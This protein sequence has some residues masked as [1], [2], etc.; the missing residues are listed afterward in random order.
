MI[1]DLTAQP[2][3]LM[4]EADVLVIGAG[5]AGLL[6]ASELRKSRVSVIVLESGAREQNDEVHP[7]NRVVQLADEYHGATYGRSRCLG[8]TSTR[9]GGALIP[10]LPFDL[11]ARTHAGLATWPIRLNEV[12]PFLRPIEELFAV[13][14]GSYDEAFVEEYGA[15]DIIP[16]GD[17]DFIPRFAKWPRFSRRNVAT[18]LR[19]QIE[20]DPDLSIWLNATATGFE[21]DEGTRRVR[22]VT[23]YH[24]GGRRIVVTADRIVICAGAIESTRLL[25]LLDA[26][27]GNRVFE[28]NETLG[29]YLS[30]HI[31]VRTA[32]I[33]K[34]QAVRLNRLAGF[35]FVGGTMRSLRFEL[36]PSAQNKERI[37]C[38]FGHISFEAIGET[39]FD[40]L[41]SLLREYQKS[42]RLR[43]DLAL[44]TL[45]DFPYLAR[46]LAWRCFHRQLHWPSPARYDLHTV[47]EQL[48]RASNSI[49]LSHE[50]DPFGNPL[51][52][53]DWKIHSRD[54]EAVWAYARRFDLYWKR[55][56]LSKIGELAWVDRTDGHDG[57]EILAANDIYH[58]CGTT[59]MGADRCSAV[60]DAN[61]RVWAL[62]NL[63]VA[64]TSVLP[65]G[66]SANPTLMLMLLTMRLARNVA[67]RLGNS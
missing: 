40:T 17:P 6:L 13:D 55:H 31:S 15:R 48:P 59:R 63:W 29:K 11:E 23:A 66:A 47:V 28:G 49:R 42:A 2:V 52:A 45:G 10:F 5:I 39:G 43:R 61:L 62:S 21:L 16:T 22:T 18:L 12:L 4:L 41:R 24:M 58:P 67:A 53:I 27:N 56:G 30:D 65:S 19:S 54:Q 32:A 7:L 44:R 64:S 1:A 60:V 57:H 35:R 34:A 9:W 46:A 26:Q 50:K 37:G 14:H 8:G 3:D 38:A 33:K 20:E 36:S 51:A 25:L